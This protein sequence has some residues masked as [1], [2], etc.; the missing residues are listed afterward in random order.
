MLFND[1]GDDNC[2]VF[3]TFPSEVYEKAGFRIN[4]FKYVEQLFRKLPVLFRASDPS[5]YAQ[6]IIFSRRL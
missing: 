5:T 6:K 3:H 4:F 1:V 2:T